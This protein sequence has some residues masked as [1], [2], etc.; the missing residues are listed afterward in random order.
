MKKIII[1]GGVIGIAFGA[2]A[3][4]MADNA[5]AVISENAGVVATDFPA[6]PADFPI[7]AE[8]VVAE[9]HAAAPKSTAPAEKTKSFK[10]MIADAQ[11]NRDNGGKPVES[12]F[13]KMVDE[14]RK[15]GKPADSDFADTVEQLKKEAAE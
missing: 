10:E 5:N 8:S 4:Q 13:A 3:A 2:H 15:S 6:A 7:A 1:I 12:S 11:R 14:A 9:S